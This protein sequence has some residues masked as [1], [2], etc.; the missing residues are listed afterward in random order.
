M[1]KIA[2]LIVTFFYLG[3]VKFAPGT[4]GSIVAFPLSLLVYRYLPVYEF[5]QFNITLLAIAVALFIVGSF[6]VR[7]IWD[8]MGYMILGKLLLMK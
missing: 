7:Y 5:Y 2:E 4:L 8:T 6:L 1:I 3:K